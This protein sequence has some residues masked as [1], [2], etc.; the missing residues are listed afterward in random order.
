VATDDVYK[1]TVSATSQNQLYQNTLYVRMKTAVQPIAGDF[2]TTVDAFKNVWQPAQHQ[3]VTW[4][5]WQAVQQAGVGITVIANECRREGGLQFGGV[6]TAPLT[7]GNA[8]SEALPPQC[9][10]VAT[11]L[12]GFTGRRKRGRW[13]GF[14]FSET[15]QS[16]GLWGSAATTGI[17][18]RMNSFFS[19]YGVGGSNASQLLG[20]WSERTATGCEHVPGGPKHNLVDAPHPELAFTPATIY[21]LRGVVFTQRRRTLG[22]GR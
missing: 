22:V 7:G 4:T 13:Y 18:T 16:G 15:D 1:L 14:G 6:L 8:V 10:M 19:T 9:A 11:I 3:G 20:V 21:A 2:Q 12:T 5:T 17:A